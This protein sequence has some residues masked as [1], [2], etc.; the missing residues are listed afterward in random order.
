M[1]VIF[2]ETRQYFEWQ[3]LKCW[4]VKVLHLVFS[5]P[6]LKIWQSRDR[7]GIEC[8]RVYNPATDQHLQFLSEQE[9]MAWIEGE[10][11]HRRSL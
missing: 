4:I 3:W 7:F 6:D 2:K 9:L 11:Q 5:P 10:Y 1:Q 8:W